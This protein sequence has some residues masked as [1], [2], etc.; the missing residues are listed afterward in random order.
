MPK[1]V[2]KPIMITA[3]RMDCAFE[4]ATLEGVMRG[5]AGDWVIEGVQGEH[6]P[7]KDDIFRATYEPVDQEGIDALA[8]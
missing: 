7:C 8:V 3:R 6:Y 1:F 5:Q 2:K 4:C